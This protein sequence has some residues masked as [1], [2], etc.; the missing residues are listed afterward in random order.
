MLFV[1]RAYIENI[2]ILIRDAYMDKIKA[3]NRAKIEVMRSRQREAVIWFAK[4]DLSGKELIYQE[5][6]V[7]NYVGLSIVDAFNV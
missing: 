4:S 6:D 1:N 3:F 5:K 7:L 2:M